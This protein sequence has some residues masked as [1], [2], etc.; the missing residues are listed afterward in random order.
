MR[1][2]LSVLPRLA[3]RPRVEDSPEVYSNAH[4]VSP[5]T[6]TSVPLALASPVVSVASVLVAQ[7]A[8]PQVAYSRPL[9]VLAVWVQ[10]VS[11]A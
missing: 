6:V 3:S 9:V 11:P 8:N 1:A 10:A 7:V 4:L 2:G 5:E